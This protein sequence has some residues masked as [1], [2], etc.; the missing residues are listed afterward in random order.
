[1]KIAICDDEEIF[2]L[3]ICNLLDEYA[4]LHK[5]ITITMSAF[6]SADD[7]LRAVE[8]F[9]GFDIYILDIVMPGMNGIELGTELRQ[10]GADGDIL[11]LSSSSDYAID[12]YKV[13]A[14]NYILKPI[15]KSD[16]LNAIEKVVSTIQ[17]TTKTNIIVKTKEATVRIPLSDILYAQLHRR[18]VLY[19]LANG[20]VIESITIRVPFVDVLKEAL[21]NKQFVLC[22]T[23]LAFNLH[24]IVSVGTEEIIFTG[25]RSILFSKN[26]CRNVRSLWSDFWLNF[27]E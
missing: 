11:Y 13:D 17:N 6:S 21:A 10:Y 5:D 2:R 1:M 9:G 8:K 3:R 7:C 20:D 18:T 16:F 27:S 23:S 19:Y 12:S 14:S 25:N 4:S 22:G 24:N 26:V 15:I